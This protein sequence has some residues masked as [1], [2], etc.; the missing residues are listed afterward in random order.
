MLW[1]EHWSDVHGS[2]ALFGIWWYNFFKCGPN[3]NY[4]KKGQ[5]NTI[6]AMSDFFSLAVYLEE[7][8]SDIYV[9]KACGT[10][11]INLEQRS[12]CVTRLRE[13]HWCIGS[14]MTSLFRQW[15]KK[16]EGMFVRGVWGLKKSIHANNGCSGKKKVPIR[17]KR[18]LINHRR[19]FSWDSLLLEWP[20]SACQQS[21]H[22][23]AKNRYLRACFPAYTDGKEEWKKKWMRYVRCHY[24]CV[25]LFPF[26]NWSCNLIWV[27]KVNWTR[28]QLKVL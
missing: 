21:A 22:T 26:Q 9:V 24:G 19:P 16:R 5:G 1:R 3:F 10:L 14:T 27:Q 17:L 6:A 15:K 7:I 8:Y 11:C 25:Y 4:L 20:R 13:C 28:I 23:A 18:Y 2:R 12:Y